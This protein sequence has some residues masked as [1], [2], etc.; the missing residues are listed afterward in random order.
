[1]D[2]K[3]Q[4]DLT[5]TDQSSANTGSDN[6]SNEEA[7]E[8]DIV[9]S[10]S[11]ECFY[12]YFYLGF[13]ILVSTPT[14]PSLLP[15]SQNGHIAGPHRPAK[16]E[17]PD[18]LVATKLVLHGN[19]PGSY[20]FNRHRRCRWEI[21]YL[22]GDTAVNSEAPFAQMEGR[23]HDEWKSV[24]ASEED[25]KQ[26]QRGMVLNRGWGD[27]PGSSCELLGGW[28]GDVGALGRGVK[29]AEDSTTTLY[30]FPGLV[31]EVLKNGLVS[32]LTVF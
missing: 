21:S 10:V 24:Y 22:S 12:N 30:G 28:E 4:E 8:E 6:D 19:V 26:R 29:G 13:D 11:S 15:P 2:F 7:V 31:F 3:R 25:A 9:G 18:R 17:S 23:L 1:M 5:D 20:P 32:G 14:A 27:S 16:A